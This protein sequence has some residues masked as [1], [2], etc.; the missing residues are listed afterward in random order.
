MFLGFYSLLHSDYK[1]NLY[2]L[3]MCFVSSTVL[4]IYFTVINHNLE[5]RTNFQK[6]SY[7]EEV[8]GMRS[9]F[10][11]SLSE[12]SH[13]FSFSWLSSL[14]LQW[15]HIVFILK[16]TIRGVRDSVLRE[17]GMR[18]WYACLLVSLNYLVYVSFIDCLHYL[19]S[20]LATSCLLALPLHIRIKSFNKYEKTKVS[21]L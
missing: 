7:K 6:G 1:E 5:S 10:L 15:E 16:S 21:C 11:L 12:C 9:L 4:S 3:D 2:L 17:S 19:D 18:V 13:S 14:L 20:Y 8:S